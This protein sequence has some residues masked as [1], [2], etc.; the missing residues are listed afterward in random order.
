MKTVSKPIGTFQKVGECLYR[1]SSN[2]VYYGRTKVKGK[3]IRR[4]LQTI[5]RDLAKRRLSG[6]KDELARVDHSKGKLTLAELCARYLLTVQHLKPKT[7]ERKTHIV[8]RIKR[9]WPA[10][11]ACQV[12]KIRPS[13][14]QLW[15][16]K[17][18]FGPV[19]R[20]QHLLCLKSIFQMAIADGVITQSPAAAVA[21]VKLSKPIRETPTWEQFQ[22]ILGDI[23]SQHFSSDATE[24]GDFLEFLG[25]AGLGQAEAAALRWSDIDFERGTIRTFRHKTQSGFSIPI[26]PMLRPLLE[27]RK[28]ISSGQESVFRQKTVRKALAGACRRLGFPAYTQRSLRRMFVVWAIENGVDV[29]VISEWQGH[30]DGGK[31]IL[32]TYSHVNRSHSQAMAQKMVANEP[33]NVGLP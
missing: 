1:Y 27:R 8:C 31:L 20:N 6:L 19:S 26:Y 4:S 15:L 3:E 5:D 14:V 12:G 23:R 32:D 7:V 25:L 21:P 9:D 29:K 24:S 10:G 2:G 30:K 33:D 13:H 22:E 18:H 16:A 17:Y 28:A 11:S